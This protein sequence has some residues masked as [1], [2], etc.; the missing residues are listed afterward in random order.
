MAE[1]I[2]VAATALSSD[3]DI[4]RAEAFTREPFVHPGEEPAVALAPGTPRRRAL[5]QALAELDAGLKVPSTPWRREFSLLLGLE[6]VLSEEEPKLADGTT[7]SAH[8]VDALSGTLTA[9]LAEATSGSNGNGVPSVVM[10][11]S[12][13]DSVRVRATYVTL[14]SNARAMSATAMYVVPP[15][16][17]GT[18]LAGDVRP[19]QVT[20]APPIANRQRCSPRTMTIRSPSMTARSARRP[21]TGASGTITC[22]STSRAGGALGASTPLITI[23]TASGFTGG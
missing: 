15:E 17:K 22:P 9:L 16:A 3:A 23:A 6:R 10:R 21:T 19:S 13:S 5:E 8:Q 7:L 14:A 4:A 2:T 11:G 12:T 1:P 20:A 18:T